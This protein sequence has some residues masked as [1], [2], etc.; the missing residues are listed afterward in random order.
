[1]RISPPGTWLAP[2][3]VSH[4]SHF[5]GPLLPPAPPGNGHL[6][7]TGEQVAG[8]P[9]RVRSNGRDPGRYCPHGTL[10]QRG[11][12]GW[13]QLCPT[14]WDCLLELLCACVCVCARASCT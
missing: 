13:L 8:A 14:K 5:H 1:M 7:D 10:L 9:P 12:E 11:E 6:R 4:S 2:G 3:P